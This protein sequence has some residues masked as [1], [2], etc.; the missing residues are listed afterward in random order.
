MVILMYYFE[1]HEVEGLVCK[2][3]S[4]QISLL[5]FPLSIV[6]T[7]LIDYDKFLRGKF[8]SFSAESV[9]IHSFHS[10][11]LNAII[12]VGSLVHFLF[13]TVQSFFCSIFGGL[14]TYL[15]TILDGFTSFFWWFLMV[16]SYCSYIVKS[17]FFRATRHHFQVLLATDTL[18]SQLSDLELRFVLGRETLG[19]HLKVMVSWSLS[20]DD[21]MIIYID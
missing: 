6:G 14:L 5:I 13:L 2:I 4:P 17:Q 21:S 19:T 8:Q 7:L 1:K 11:W 16:Q 12:F 18:V 15:L 20:S 10:W 9:S 3:L